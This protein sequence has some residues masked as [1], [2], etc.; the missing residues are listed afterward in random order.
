MT[1]QTKVLDIR[2]LVRL[3]AVLSLLLAGVVA[4]APPSSATG[5]LLPSKTVLTTDAAPAVA[6]GDAH[7]T[8]TVSILNVGFRPVTPHGTVT[9]TLTPSVGD[10]V[11]LNATL[12]NCTF[13]PRRCTA[14]VT[15]HL[16][17]DLMDGASVVAHYNGDLVAKPSTSN[18]IYQ[19][20][21]YP[22]SCNADTFCSSYTSSNT[23]TTDIY[24]QV[25]DQGV[26][27][28]YQIE[29]GFSPVPLSCTKKGAG[30]TAVWNVTYPAAKEVT[31][32]TYGATAVKSKYTPTRICYSSDQ[33]FRTKYGSWAKQVAP[34]VY[35]GL[36]PLC[37]P[38]SAGPCVS[39][40]DFYP[41]G[42]DCE[43]GCPAQLNTYIR[44]PEGDP[45]T[46]H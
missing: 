34:G 44:A 45:K 35:E 30:D 14:V 40:A 6:G 3:L 15:A 39:G 41:A 21:A 43:G 10:P 1:V 42:G 29:A 37:K 8:A 23:G 46:T 20:T 18:E 4:L 36:L 16:T 2:P 19:S 31:Y 13:F 27:Q 38:E 24:I 25:D 5:A 32:T 12:G 7:L 9:F 28:D 26:D 17:D 22:T 11:V 33:P